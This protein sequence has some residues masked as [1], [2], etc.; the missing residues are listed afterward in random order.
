MRTALKKLE[1]F[2]LG[3]VALPALALL[4]ACQQQAVVTE[5]P[6]EQ[7]EETDYGCSYFY[8]LWGRQAELGLRFEEAMEAYE[9]A[10]I[11]DPE[12]EFIIRKI[13]I[14]LLRMDRGEEAITMLRN[15]LVKKPMDSGVR[16]LLAR[17]YAGLGHYEKAADEYRIIH[18]Q[19]PE[20]VSSLLLLSELYLNLKKLEEAELVLRKLL[21]VNS[22]SYPARVMLAR[23][24]MA[25]RQYQAAAD[26]YRKAL[27]ID[28][29]ADL[30]IEMSDVYVQQKDYD[31]V[32]SLYRE[33]L[34]QDQ[35]ERVA[36]ALINFLLLQNRELDALAELDRLKSYVEEPGSIDLSM[37]R[38]YARMGKYDQAVE[39]V[40]SYLDRNNAADARYLLAVILAQAEE[41]EQAV[42][43]LRLIGRDAAEYEDA[44]IFQ[45]RILRFLQQTDQAVQVLE[46]AIQYEEERTPDMYVMLAALYQLQERPDLG[47]DTF[48]RALDAFPD[49]DELLYEYGLFLDTLGSKEEALSVM[50]EVIERQPDH[51]EALNYVGYS[52]ADD[53]IH[54]DQALLF[55]ERAVSLEPENGY[56]RDSLGW[57][58]FKLGRIQEAA[59]QLEEAVRLIEND[60]LIHDHLGDVYLELGRRDDALEAYNRALSL[61]K[62]GSD[63]RNALQEKIKLFEDREK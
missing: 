30:V 58:Y 43:E 18:R 34:E 12:A 27:D 41:F 9:K 31:R 60:P 40:R 32:I 56:M 29:S 59:Q 48:N 11:C 52:W 51:S 2:I 16:M 42:D 44:V 13:P 17:V 22:S 61:F 24:H 57:V 46:N 10:L 33:I 19:N 53:S 54:L 39:I 47:K 4:P 5:Y 28:W 49:N 26:E 38:L 25:N 23:I 1:F 63:E 35:N 45:V 50:Q 3:M 15:F 36:L 8:F 7:V 14:L 6:E 20:E 21:E 37:A 55:V 62:E